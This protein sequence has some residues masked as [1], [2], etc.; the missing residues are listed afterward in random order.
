MS[1]Q[2]AMAGSAELHFYIGNT[3]TNLAGNLREKPP[4]R[5]SLSWQNMFIEF[6]GF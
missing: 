4:D 1:L 2:P 6:R 3:L 5:V